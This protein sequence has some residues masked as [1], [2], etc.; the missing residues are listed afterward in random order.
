[1]EK[2]TAQRGQVLPLVALL[3]VVL[4]GFTA[5]AVDVGYDRYE[6]RIQQ[7]AADS[8]ALAGAAEIPFGNV[9]KSARYDASQN[10]FTDNTVNGTCT[11]CVTVNNPYN[12]DSKSVEVIVSAQHPSFF[13]R[14][15]GT[16]SVTVTARAVAK[17]KDD[18]GCLYLLATKLTNFNSATVNAH[19]CAIISN[20]DALMSGTVDAAGI[21]V[22][23]FNAAHFQNGTFPSAQP[24]KLPVPVSDPCQR[25]AG[26]AYLRSW[27]PP[28]TCPDLSVSSGSVYPGCYHNLTIGGNV[29]FTGGV[30]QPYVVTNRLDLSSS[31]VTGSNVILYMGNGAALRANGATLN[32]TAP[33]SGN[34]ANVALFDPYN[35]TNW[36]KVDINVS[37]LLY[38]PGGHANFNHSFGTY[39]VAVFAYVNFNA[40]LLTFNLPGA[41]NGGS[42]IKDAILSE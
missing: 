11:V 35:N 17:L 14:V 30:D 41:S 19:N 21:E 5:L 28:T 22:Y 7:S 15:L 6:K 40:S 39:T 26:C 32:F 23:N 24:T 9:T 13:Q 4:M 37:G 27:K 20:G 10:G 1:M 25:I 18:N 33:T 12:N 8:A 42:L 34:M 31:T 29:T 2:Y 3:I 36:D 38:V 16:T